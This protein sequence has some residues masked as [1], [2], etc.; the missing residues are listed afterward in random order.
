MNVESGAR[1]GISN[2]YRSAL[3]A[4]IM[5]SKIPNTLS[6]LKHDGEKMGSE[7]EIK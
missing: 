7:K 1:K 2:I 6:V 5:A 4:W 3:F